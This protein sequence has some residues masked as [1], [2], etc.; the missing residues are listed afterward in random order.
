MAKKI[1]TIEILGKA[2]REIRCP[3]E[4]DGG[5]VTID[6]KTGKCKICKRVFKIVETDFTYKDIILPER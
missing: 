5:D 1:P 2:N 3:F 4:C 6:P